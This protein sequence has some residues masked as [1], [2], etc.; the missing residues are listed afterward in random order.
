M[1]SIT[2]DEMV[3]ELVRFYLAYDEQPEYQDFY[4]YWRGVLQLADH[5]YTFGWAEITDKGYEQVVEAYNALAELGY[6]DEDK[7]PFEKLFEDNE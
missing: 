4:T 7:D 5:Q 2:N 3:L 6:F 1:K